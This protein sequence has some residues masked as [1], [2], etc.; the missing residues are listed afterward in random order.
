MILAS[1]I[2][3]ALALAITYAEAT[4]DDLAYEAALASDAATYLAR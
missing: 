2:A 3:I 1:A 4:A